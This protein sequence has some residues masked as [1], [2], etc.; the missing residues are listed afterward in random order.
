MEQS[1]KPALINQH[2]SLTVAGRGGGGGGQGLGTRL[3]GQR[4]M[5]SDFGLQKLMQLH[6]ARRETLP[7]RDS[8]CGGFYM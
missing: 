7:P 2:R 5:S 8:I 6:Q 1:H 3:A 4:P